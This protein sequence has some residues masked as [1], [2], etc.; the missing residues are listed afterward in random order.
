MRAL[1]IACS[2]L[3]SIF[4]YAQPVVPS[5]E[6]G[7]ASNDSLYLYIFGRGSD[8]KSAILS[9][10]F[11]ISGSLISHVG[12]GVVVDTGIA[13]AHV[14]N[15][16]GNME[17]ALW[18]QSVNDF[19]LVPGIR[20]AAV[21]RRLIHRSE[22]QKI[23]E[24]VKA[25]SLQFVSFDYDFQIG[26]QNRLYCSEFCALLLC[27]VFRGDEMCEPVRKTL[28]DALF[29]A[30]LNREIFIYYPVDFFIPGGRFHLLW[31]WSR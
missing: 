9:A 21:W 3:A 6:P 25:L 24:Q 10:H 30:Y 17:S 28:H 14:V 7:P 8:A 5:L 1:C 4:G 12:I 13:V 2:L 26:G 27:D 22:L 18:I 23:N 31:E 16:A 11:N 20:Y 15:D 29:E 19:M